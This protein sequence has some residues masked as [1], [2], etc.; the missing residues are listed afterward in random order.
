MAHSIRFPR[1]HDKADRNGRYAV[2]LCI[3]KNKRR[4]YIALDLYADPA[5]WDEAGEQFIILR[6]LKGAEQKAENKQREADNALL[7]KYK[8]RAREIVERFEIEGIDWT[9]N[10]FEDAFLN[11]SKQGKFN[12]YFTDRIAELH[13]TGHIGNSQTY[14]QTQDMLRSYDRKLDQ[15]LFSDIDLRSFSKL[16]IRPA[17]ACTDNVD[18]RLRF[19]SGEGTIFRHY[20][21]REFANYDYAA[22]LGPTGREYAEVELCPGDGCYYITTR[23]LTSTGETVTV[24]T[25]N[26]S[27]FGETGPNSLSLYKTS[28]AQYFT[29][30]SSVTL[31][32]VKK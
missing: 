11:T 23:K 29:A 30:G 10:Q 24:C 26:A 22:G 28:S 2:R 21:N 13:A 19:G 14:K 18:Y 9:L 1:R 27:N 25:T 20:V 17:L 16:I 6:N 3:T 12:A 31:Y 15:R 8:V 7:A 4:K 5:Y 32:G